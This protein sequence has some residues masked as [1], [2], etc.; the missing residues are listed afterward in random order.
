MTMY[1]QTGENTKWAETFI[2]CLSLIYE[3]VYQDHLTQL[4]PFTWDLI[5]E[6]QPSNLN[7]KIRAEC[8]LKVFVIWVWQMYI[9]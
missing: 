6:G 7:V 8:K 3:I 4:L 5:E 1:L 9:W 2:L